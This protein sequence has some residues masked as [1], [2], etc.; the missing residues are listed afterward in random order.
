MQNVVARLCNREMA[1]CSFRCKLSFIFSDFDGCDFPR[2]S[3]A[4]K[5]DDTAIL[6]ASLITGIALHSKTENESISHVSALSVCGL[7]DSATTQHDVEHAHL[8]VDKDELSERLLLFS[9]NRCGCLLRRIPTASV[10]FSQDDETGLFYHICVFLNKFDVD[11][12]RTIARE[13]NVADAVEIISDSKCPPAFTVVC[14]PVSLAAA[15]A[16]STGEIAFNIAHQEVTRILRNSGCSSTQI[17]FTRHDSRKIE[18]CDADPTLLFNSVMHMRV[19]VP[20]DHVEDITTR[21]LEVARALNLDSRGTRHGLVLSVAPLVERVL[22]KLPEP[23]HGRLR[24]HGPSALHGGPAGSPFIYNATISQRFSGGRLGSKKAELCEKRHPVTE[25]VDDGKT[26]C[27][28]LGC[29]LQLGRDDNCVV[30]AVSCGHDRLEGTSYSVTL[31]DSRLLKETPG[32]AVNQ[33]MVSNPASPSLIFGTYAFNHR[34]VPSSVARTVPALGRTTIPQETIKSIADYSLFDIPPRTIT[35]R[36]PQPHLS[37]SLE[38]ESM[39]GGA[40]CLPPTDDYMGSV[41]FNGDNDRGSGGGGGRLLDVVGFAER[42]FMVLHDRLRIQIPAVQVTYI[43]R[44]VAGMMAP[45]PGDS[46]G[47]VWIRTAGGKVLHS[48]VSAEVSLVSDPREIFYTL[49]PAHFVLDSVREWQRLH[50]PE[51][52]ESQCF[53]RFR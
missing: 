7:V 39:P 10:K 53:V 42:H 23:E 48:F 35:N 18:T 3:P 31:E 28:S 25:A 49:T 20:I 4:D 5:L 22:C 26:K 51:L 17:L 27:S 11:D 34:A 12:A 14:C 36:E 45:E 29:Y 1:F 21:V 6:P 43:A 15:S 30:V 9:S 52:E 37:C 46:G 24:L 50:H 38:V 2:L 13:F 19:C 41:E 40:V 47:P 33:V 44:A 32:V 16:D 8:S